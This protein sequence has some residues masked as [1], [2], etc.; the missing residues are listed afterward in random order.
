MSFKP[1]ESFL[2][3]YQHEPTKKI[4]IA[5]SHKNLH[6][7][8][9]LDPQRPGFFNLRTYWLALSREWG[10][11]PLHWY[12]GDETSLI[13]YES[14]Q[15]AYTPRSY[16]G[17]FTLTIGGSKILRATQP[18]KVQPSD[19]VDS[20]VDPWQQPVMSGDVGMLEI[21]VGTQTVCVFF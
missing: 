7:K 19:V 11:Q 4:N 8:D 14:G 6:P 18:P 3:L 5:T 13:P 10:N 15:L 20:K 9:I 21:T 12:I 16:T 1:F 2:P 17:S